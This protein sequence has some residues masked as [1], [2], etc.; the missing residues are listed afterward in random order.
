MGPQKHEEGE[1]GGIRS[2]IK[3]NA[4]YTA[5]MFHAKN[6]YLEDRYKDGNRVAEIN[7]HI[8]EKKAREEGIRLWI[9]VVS[10]ILTLISVFQQDTYVQ[11]C[12]ILFS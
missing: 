6:E 10:Y 2:R 1:E 8:E 9:L 4:V 7:I 11:L 12:A 5:Q 3:V